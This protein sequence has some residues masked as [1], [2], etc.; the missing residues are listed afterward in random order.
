MA[1]DMTGD[2]PDRRPDMA[3]PV[4]LVPIV[5]QMHV[6]CMSDACQ[7]RVRCMSDTCRPDMAAPVILVPI[8]SVKSTS[9]HLPAVAYESKQHPN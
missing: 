9:L 4:S 7:M 3:A 8:V 6:R 5:C 2:G 1:M